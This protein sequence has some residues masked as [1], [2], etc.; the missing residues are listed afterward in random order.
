VNTYAERSRAA[1]RGRNAGT[2]KGKA[3]LYW[4]SRAPY[5]FM[6]AA[7]DDWT[8]EDLFAVLPERAFTIRV[9]LANS[10]ARFNLIDSTDVFALLESLAAPD[11]LIAGIDAA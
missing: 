8:D 5:D 11:N 9:G 10:R 2:H 3:G 4:L 1:L 7:G 6:L